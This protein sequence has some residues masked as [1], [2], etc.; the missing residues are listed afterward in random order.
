MKRPKDYNSAR[1][2]CVFK[3]D[4]RVCMSMAVSC[5]VLQNYLSQLICKYC[6]VLKHSPASFLPYVDWIRSSVP[7]LSVRNIVRDRG[8]LL[9]MLKGNLI[10]P[11]MLPF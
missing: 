11:V 7:F 6:L 5:D 1:S 3:L 4:N 8:H 9:T 2:V 10:V